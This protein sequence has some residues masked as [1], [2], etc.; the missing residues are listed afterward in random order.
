MS[1]F[2]CIR[3]RGKERMSTCVRVC[4]CVLECESVC[5]CTLFLILKRLPAASFA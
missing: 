5:V 1:A 2:V 3:E 4:V